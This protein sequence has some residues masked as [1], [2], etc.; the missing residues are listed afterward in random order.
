MCLSNVLE[1][2]VEGEG[3]LNA[4]QTMTALRAVNPSLRDADENFI[5]TVS[6]ATSYIANTTML[7]I[8]SKLRQ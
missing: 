2:D 5:Y 7:F 1:A 6:I 8:C 3:Y 4:T